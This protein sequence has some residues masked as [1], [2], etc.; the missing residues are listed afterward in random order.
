[1]AATTA[2]LTAQGLD[3]V[4]Q[5]VDKESLVAEGLTTAGLTRAGLAAVEG[6]KD[7]EAEA[8]RVKGIFMKYSNILF[9]YYFHIY[10]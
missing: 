6:L 5:G 3:A 9:L 8:E 7:R 2:G 1:M 4:A 10:H